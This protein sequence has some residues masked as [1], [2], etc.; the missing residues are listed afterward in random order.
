MFGKTK[1]SFFRNKN[2]VQ[3]NVKILMFL[4]ILSTISLPNNPKI[5]G[6]VSLE[7]SEE[8]FGS[9]FLRNRSL[10]YQLL[11]YESKSGS[12]DISIHNITINQ[13]ISIVS[14]D[15]VCVE[16]CANYSVIEGSKLFYDLDFSSTKDIEIAYQINT[17]SNQPLNNSGNLP[18]YLE[19][20]WQHNYPKKDGEIQFNIFEISILK[21]KKEIQNISYSGE[22]KIFFG[23]LEI[24][25]VNY[26]VSNDFLNVYGCG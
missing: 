22:S 12:S 14:N 4:M 24:N 5:S 8:L 9:D 19:D 17:T 6:S 1:N 18:I 7:H 26:D 10:T 16:E 3:T 11:I 2:H 20:G 13:N 15:K 23:E 25:A 21:G